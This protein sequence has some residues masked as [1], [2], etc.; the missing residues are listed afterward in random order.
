MITRVLNAK[1]EVVHD[2]AEAGCDTSWDGY[3]IADGSPVEGRVDPGPGWEQVD[4]R[5]VRAI[6]P[7]LPA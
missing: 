2:C 1:G 7:D 5:T 6:P 3:L 4:E